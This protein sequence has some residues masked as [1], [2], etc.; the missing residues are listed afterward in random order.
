MDEVKDILKK[1]F[2]YHHLGNHKD[3]KILWYSDLKNFTV[4]EIEGAWQQWRTQKANENKIPQSFEIVQLI[5]LKNNFYGAKTVEDPPLRKGESCVQNTLISNLAKMK[6]NMP[7]LID[8]IRECSSVPEKIILCATALNEPH[9]I[10]SPVV[11]M[12]IK[13][14]NRAENAI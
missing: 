8:R 4:K 2:E 13:K 9:L 6:K 14:L 7:D 11:Q 1:I 12:L 10:K 3:L 5:K